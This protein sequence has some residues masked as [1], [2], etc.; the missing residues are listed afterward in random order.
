MKRLF[1][2]GFI[3]TMTLALPAAASAV[4]NRPEVTW[5]QA[6]LIIPGDPMQSESPCDHVY[7]TN[8]HGDIRHPC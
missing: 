3:L 8:F 7:S 4:S 6:S 5:G 2:A 1:I